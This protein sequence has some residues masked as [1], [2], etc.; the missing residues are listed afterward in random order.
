[1]Y[2][3]DIYTALG[4]IYDTKVSC[5][6]RFHAFTLGKQVGGTH[7]STGLIAQHGMPC[8]VFALSR[9]NVTL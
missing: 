2:N 1:M 6:P 8:V 4:H 3:L 5:I 9:M 7:G